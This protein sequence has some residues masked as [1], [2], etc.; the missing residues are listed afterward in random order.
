M[1]HTER[2]GGF[3]LIELL[4]VIAILGILVR[5]GLASFLSSQIKSRDSRRKSDPPAGGDVP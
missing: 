3:T 1:N 4:I 2:G 5:L